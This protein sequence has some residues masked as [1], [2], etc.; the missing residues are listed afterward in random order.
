MLNKQFGRLTVISFSYMDPKQ[1]E[2][3]WNCRCICGK[4]IE[5][6]GSSLRNGSSTSCGCNRLEKIILSVFRNGH[7]LNG[8]RS[9]EARS[10]HN[11]K[12]R[13]TYKSGR[14]F[15]LYGGRGIQFKFKNFREFYSELGPRPIGKSLDRINSN[16]HY[17]IGNVRWATPKEQTQNRRVHAK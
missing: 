15:H 12:T 5:T 13:C 10:Y 9:P 16:G 8:K 1:R 4:K 6:R 7:C 3:I 11:A 17:E 14:W 2:A